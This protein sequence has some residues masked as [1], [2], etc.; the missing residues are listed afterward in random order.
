MEFAYR[1]QSILDWRVGENRAIVT[2]DIVET[3]SVDEGEKRNGSIWENKVSLD[4]DEKVGPGAAELRISAHTV[5]FYIF[6]K[7]LFFGVVLLCSTLRAKQKKNVPE[8]VSKETVSDGTRGTEAKSSVDR[9]N[10]S[11]FANNFSFQRPPI[12]RT[13]RLKTYKTSFQ[14]LK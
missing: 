12:A 13:P 9:N 5:S 1:N 6:Q 3:Y 4:Q 7:H 2:S 8:L 14:R 10:F 11:N